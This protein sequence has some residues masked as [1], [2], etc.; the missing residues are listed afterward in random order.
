MEANRMNFGRLSR[1]HED[2]KSHYEVAV[3]G[4]GYGGG[5]AGSR[6]A[7]AGRQ[8]AIFERGREI[9]P[10]EYP[11]HALKLVEDVQT[12]LPEGHLGS[13]TALF[14]F[15]FNPDV[16]VIVGCGLGGTS[17]INANIS[18]EPEARIFEDSHWPEAVRG[19]ARNGALASQFRRAATALGATPL[20]ESSPRTAKFD[21]VS[22]VA[23]HLGRP[24]S[25]VPINVTFKDGTNWAGV[26]QKACVLCG[27]CVAGCNHGAKNTT[28]MNYLPDAVRHGAEIFTR[29]R[30]EY[31]ERDG[32]G[33]RL[34][35][36][37]MD[38]G[39]LGAAP[40]QVQVTAEIVILAAG[41]LGSTEILLRSRE[42]GLAV[43]DALGSR[44]TGN[45]DMIGFAYNSE[46]TMN[47]V[48]WGD[49]DRLGDAPVGACST[50]MLDL[51][52]G[53]PLGQTKMLVES[54]IPGAFAA[55]LP[56]AFAA[57]AKLEGVRTE[58]GAL[59]RVRAAWREWKS[60]LLGARSGAVRNSL[61][62]LVVSEDD[63]GGQLYLDGGRVR[64]A[65]P[66]AGSAPALAE[67]SNLIQ[68]ATAA[69]SGTFLRNP[70][71]NR[72][73]G[74][75]LITGH[76][77]GGCVMGDDPSEATVNERGA[78]YVR[79]GS[80]EVLPGLYVMD[81]AVI[82]RSLGVNPLLTI[83]ALAERNCERLAAE[84]GWVICY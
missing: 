54:S 67:A 13:H 63:S 70:V 21:A 55:F 77:M 20:P 75:Q 35:F 23:S 46:E 5:V 18:L 72:F 28:L 40:A 42:R 19:E 45:G 50:A 37:P 62:F 58:D 53:I 39:L 57:G 10:G 17:L 14:D 49:R 27:D 2:L 83:T 16:N 34:H 65:W 33:W 30:L 68:D 7:R 8:V 84:R 66:K 15:R 29:M 69:L 12:D 24:V 80:D 59:N 22:R 41:T 32:S 6:L 47:A 38:G 25:R 78:V 73:N 9:L 71:W 52:D 31:L 79:G 74:Q 76:P 60:L 61:I 64:V 36:Q 11:N 3:I 1:P 82:P 44:F 26:E 4:S 48:G 56:K 43:S 51:R 81:G